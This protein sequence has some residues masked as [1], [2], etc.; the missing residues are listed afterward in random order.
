VTVDSEAISVLQVFASTS[1]LWGMLVRGLG[2]G[3]ARQVACV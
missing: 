2:G 3:S 1:L